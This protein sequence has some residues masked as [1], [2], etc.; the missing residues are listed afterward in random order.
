ML[1]DDVGPRGSEKNKPEKNSSR[2]G[3][4]MDL[5]CFSVP[6]PHP[7]SRLFLGDLL[8][9]LLGLVDYCVAV[10]RE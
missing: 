3:N 4:F 5:N 9:T 1:F 7:L 10:F 8:V 2:L 6:H